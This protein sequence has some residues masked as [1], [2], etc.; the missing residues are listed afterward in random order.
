MTIS[1]SKKYPA[2]WSKGIVYK[3]E[4]YNIKFFVILHDS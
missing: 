2:P 3:Y 4:G 1:F